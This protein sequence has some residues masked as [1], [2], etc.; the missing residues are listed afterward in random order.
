MTTYNSFDGSITVA[1]VAVAKVLS[2]DITLDRQTSNIAF[3]GELF[4]EAH[5]GA[6]T[7]TGTVN[8]G[9]LVGANTQQDAL[10]TNAF[11]A[12]SD[13]T[14]VLRYGSA[15]GNHTYSGTFKITSLNASIVTENGAVATENYSF[16]STGTVTPG[17]ISG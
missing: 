4:T 5:Q 10:K 15:A 14:L 11:A 8:I 13:T 3:A 16:V 2:G 7:L 9:R 6:I 17:T 12:N 1:G